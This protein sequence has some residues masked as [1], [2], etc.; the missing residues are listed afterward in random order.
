MEGKSM[1]GADASDFRSGFATAQYYMA[2]GKH[3]LT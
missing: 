1:E 2:H 3:H